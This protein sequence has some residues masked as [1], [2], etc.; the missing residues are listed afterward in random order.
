MERVTSDSEK[1]FGCPTCAKQFKTAHILRT[2]RRIHVDEKT[3]RC[4]QCC[5]RFHQKV[6]LKYHLNVHTNQRPYRCDLC[7]KGFNQ[8]SN[9][10]VHREICERKLATN[11]FGA[12]AMAPIRSDAMT[13]AERDNRVPFVGVFF[14]DGSAKLYRA[15]NRD[16]YCLLRPANPD[17]MPK[18]TQRSCGDEEDNTIY[19]VAS[20]QQR[21]VH[22]KC[23]PGKTNEFILVDNCRNHVASEAA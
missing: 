13:K 14:A 22:G 18:T 17:D 20:V 21:N 12:I 8:P 16:D 15:H 7:S 2:H 23:E 5:M 1:R 6:N 9:L 19:I 3:Y 11:G 10:R 4:E